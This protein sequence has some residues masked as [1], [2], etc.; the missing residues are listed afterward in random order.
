M[1]VVHQLLPRD[2]LRSL[3][4]DLIEFPAAPRVGTG[5]G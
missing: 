2:L 3:V 4:Q 5:Q 1:V